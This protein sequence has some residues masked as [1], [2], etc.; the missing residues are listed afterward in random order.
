MK[1]KARGRDDDLDSNPAGHY[2]QSLTN[3]LLS[4]ALRG[5]GGDFAAS[6]FETKR[7]RALV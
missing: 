2:E 7:A 1:I 3:E 4:R 5:D 6:I